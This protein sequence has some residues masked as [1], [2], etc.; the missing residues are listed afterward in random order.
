MGPIT[1]RIQEL[2]A[3]GQTEEALELLATLEQGAEAAAMAGLM[4]RN[5]SHNVGDY[6][7]EDAQ[8]SD[9]K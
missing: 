2:M 8:A 6:I 7:A 9:E 3:A 4:T 5:M 1:Q